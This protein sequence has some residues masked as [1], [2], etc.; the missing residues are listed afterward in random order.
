M[1]FR[2]FV[3]LVFVVVVAVDYVIIDVVVND[4]VVNLVVVEEVERNDIQP[5]LYHHH[6]RCSRF[7]KSFSL[8]GSHFFFNDLLEQLLK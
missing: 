7:K 4:V 1:N 3:V 5:L 8:N 2:V 6:R